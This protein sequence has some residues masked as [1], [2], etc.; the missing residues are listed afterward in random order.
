VQAAPIA[1]VEDNYARAV[2]LKIR[3]FRDADAA[4][5]AE[6]LAGL[7]PAEEVV[8]ALWIVHQRRMLP[9]RKRPLWL[10]AVVNGEP[11]GLGRDD[12]QIF[13][14]TPGLRR[15]W[16]GVRPELRRRGVGSQLWWRM[17]AHAREVGALTLRSWAIADAPEGERFLLARGF[18]R[19]RREL[20]SW[21]D[22]VSLDAGLID[23]RDAEA[24]ERGFRVV[25]LRDV[26]TTKESALRQLFLAADR[27]APGRHQSPPPVA[28]STFRRVILRNPLLDQDCSTVV[29]RGHEPVALCWLKGDPALARYGIE[30]TATAP[31]WRGQS[32][33]TLAKLCALRLAARKGVRWV[34]TANDENNGPMLAVNRKLGHRPLPDLMVY[35]RRLGEATDP[36][37]GN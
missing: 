9:A 34:G 29:L 4:P 21:I 15:T 31:A 37:R 18:T 19:A 8:T 36:F 25:I 22:P 23:R 32:L 5:L 10:V 12:P 17:V 30:F 11:V 3:R 2:D 35:E 7:A 24:R 27:D 1:I 13:G 20:Q 28:A 14:G 6:W 33:A 26:L 16:V